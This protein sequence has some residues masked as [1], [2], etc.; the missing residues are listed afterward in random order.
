VGLVKTGRVDDVRGLHSGD[1]LGEGDAGGLEPGEVGDDVVLGNLAALDNDRA[2]AV[3][4]VE[5][6][7]QIVG[8]NLLQPR[9]GDGIRG[10]GVAVEGERCV[11][12]EHNH[13]KNKKTRKKR[14]GLAGGGGGGGGR[15]GLVMPGTLL[16]AS[17]I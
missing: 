2:N 4:A 15:Q 16:M 3:H 13:K 7:P 12:G 5:R 1:E 17:S 8:G 10:G 14:E 9:R 6:R 11:T